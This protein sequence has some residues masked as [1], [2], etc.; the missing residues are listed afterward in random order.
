M[1]RFLSPKQLIVIC[2]CGCALL[3]YLFSQLFFSRY[4]YQSGIDYLQDKNIP[5]AQSSLKRAERK[6][7]GGDVLSAILFGN[8]VQ[9]IATAQGKAFYLKASASKD[10]TTFEDDLVASNAYYRKA[11]TILPNDFVAMSGLAT[12][13]AAQQQLFQLTHRDKKNPYDALPLFRHCLELR[14]N[15]ISLNY[16]YIRF[17]A[18]I[19][20]SDMLVDT[21]SNFAAIYPSSYSTIKKEPFYAP[22]LR[23]AFKKGALVATQNSQY[24]REAYSALS[25]ISLEEDNGADALLHYQTLLSVWPE[26]NST[27]NFFRAGQLALRELKY[28]EASTQFL[29]TLTLSNDRDESIRKIFS[30]YSHQKEHQQFIDF[31]LVASKTF[32]LTTLLE[33]CTARSL[34]EAGQLE[35]AKARLLRIPENTYSG[36]ALYYLARIYEKEKDWD[37]MELSIQR[38]TVKD[39]NNSNYHS[40][41]SKALQKQ[42]KYPQAEASVALAIEKQSKPNMWYYNQRGWVRWQRR[43]Y[44]G[45][46]SDW[47]QARKL[48]LKRALFPY[49]ISLSFKKQKKFGPAITY[50][51][52][53][54]QLE[55]NNK[56][57]QKY[58]LDLQKMVAENK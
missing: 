43:N 47:Q 38:A 19:N 41:F 57:Y 53:A 33:I 2:V 5:L 29:K 22:A 28:N 39:H 18:F 26:K 44:S 9:R 4:Y 35:L 12:T 7:P 51:K 40:L 17:L 3:V 25:A 55:P 48:D 23:E 13:E 14:P 37:N 56:R 49:Q 31:A 52:K 54:L 21:I 32:Q 58:L 36:E 10:I 6:V 24:L 30:E 50:S 15:G 46:R 27:R 1:K 45:A 20:N 42:K 8:D 16:Q 34:F 11:V